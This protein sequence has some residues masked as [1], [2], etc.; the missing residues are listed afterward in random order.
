MRRQVKFNNSV[1]LFTCQWL[2][3]KD[4]KDFVRKSRIDF[5]GAHSD[6]FSA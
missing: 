4:A 5:G 2:Y 1:N 6:V 3:W